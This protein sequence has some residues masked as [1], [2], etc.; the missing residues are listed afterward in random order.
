[1]AAAHVGQAP[2]A[3]KT[4]ALDGNGARALHNGGHDETRGD[5]RRR[6]HRQRCGALPD[7]ARDAGGAPV[8]RDG[9]GARPELRARLVRAVGIVHPAAVFDRHQPGDLAVRHHG[10]ARCGARTG[11]ARRGAASH[12][13]A[14][15]RL[16]VPGHAGGRGRAAREP[17]RAARRRCRRG[18]AGAGSTGRALSVAGD[19]RHRARLA[20]PVGRG[21]VRRLQPAAGVSRPGAGAG[22]ALR[23]GRG[24]GF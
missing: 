17:R 14:R 8:P 22:R 4:K 12:R 6:R 23:G 1:M 9:A 24:G 2:A 21:L 16:P 19:G 7:A 15:R 3:I 5:H 11:R 18:A 10:A 20:R 13:P